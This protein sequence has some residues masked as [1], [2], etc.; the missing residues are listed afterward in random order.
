MSTLI[1]QIKNE[2]IV[3]C[4]KLYVEVFNAEPWNDKWTLENAQKRLNDIYIAPNFVGSIYLDKGV[5]KGAIFG[6]C[7]QYFNG[8]HYYLKEM[9]ISTDLQGMGIGSKLLKEHEEQLKLLGVKNIYL[10]TSKVHITSKFYT[11]ND[12]AVWNSMIMMGK[13]I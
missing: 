1:S 6:N 11:K 7:E 3:N 12:Y 13:Q 4:A 2:D 10:L 8:I 5:I 9:F